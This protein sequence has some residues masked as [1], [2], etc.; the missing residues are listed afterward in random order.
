MSDDFFGDLGKHISKYTRKAADSTGAF[1]ESTKLS[2]QIGS[3]ERAVEKLYRELGE[4]TY[5]LASAG[6]AELDPER[7]FKADSITAHKKKIR[8]MKDQL[9]K[10]RGMKICPH[11]GE[12]IEKDV[13]FCP[14]CGAPIENGPEK[15]QTKSSV[16]EEAADDAGAVDAA[17]EKVNADAGETGAKDAPFEKV[18]EGAEETDSADADF[19]PVPDE[20]GEEKAA[21]TEE[22][23]MDAE[24]TVIE[25]KP[26]GADGR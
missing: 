15:E 13:S 18:S 4:E 3:E 5:K 12:V 6:K 24:F 10:V 16:A 8:E 7:R 14:K 22:V 11:C 21:E 25:H 17:Y 26:D 23:S 2:T 1:I 19:V 9:A 20:T